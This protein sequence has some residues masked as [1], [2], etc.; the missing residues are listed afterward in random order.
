MDDH[1]T[2]PI[3]RDHLLAGVDR[4]IDPAARNA[5]AAA[6]ALPGGT[7]APIA[8][9]GALVLDEAVIAGHRR[10]IGADTTREL[11]ELFLSNLARLL[12]SANA[13]PVDWRQLGRDAHAAVSLAGSLGFMELMTAARHLAHACR[14]GAPRDDTPMDADN[15]LLRDAY[16]AAAV[17]AEGRA[18]HLIDELARDKV[19]VTAEALA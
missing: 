3:D 9:G 4:W 6:P 15:L 2:K 10:E 19:T 7:P 11:V 8:T 13:E 17:R 12:R 1:M 5:G 16:R 14:D 18:R